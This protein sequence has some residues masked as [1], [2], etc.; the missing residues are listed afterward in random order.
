MKHIHKQ[1][2]TRRRFLT[3][4][5]AA[6]AGAACRPVW[7][8]AAETLAVPSKPV[9]ELFVVHGKDTAAM[10]QA[11]I[12]RMGGW[13]AFV[14]AGRTAVVKPN[15]AWAS[16]PEQ[17]GNTDPFLVEHCVRACLAAGASDVIVPEKPCSPA[18][19]SFSMSG[20]EEAV[21]RAGGRMYTPQAKHFQTVELPR[22]VNLKQADVIKDVL[23]A[24]CLI[25][26]PVAKTHGGAGLTLSMKNWMGVVEDRGFWHRNQ[27]HQCIAD[28]STRIR[29]NLIII[30]ATRI[31]LTGG[32]R[33]PGK[34]AYPNQVIFGTD[35]VA[36]D[37]Y[38]ATL[39]DKQPFDIQHIRLAHEMGVG[40]GDLAL[41]KVEHINL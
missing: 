17:G 8:A 7:S 22:A 16:L 12:Q 23:E 5:T 39:F 36:A 4:V 15:A 40:C 20:I 9:A 34:L 32:P 2:I 31:M 27:L 3:A 41:I 6:T 1:M 11:G 26:M 37:A 29:P 13:S 24:G 21:K 38:A 18:K 28:F 10:L 33:G 19:D 14:K 35:P 30:D 25:N